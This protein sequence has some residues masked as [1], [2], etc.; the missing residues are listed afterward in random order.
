MKISVA[1][2]V[3]LFALP[4][5]I[6]GLRTPSRSRQFNAK[7]ATRPAAN[8][9]AS[10]KRKLPVPLTREQ[11]LAIGRSSH[12]HS[13]KRFDSFNNTATT[14]VGLVTAPLIPLGGEDDDED[15]AV[16]GDFNGDG[17]KDVAKLISNYI[18]DSWVD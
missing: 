2:V 13:G 3:L 8:P 18:G 10:A 6:F 4:L 14:S 16:I 11:R 7:H 9:A 12:P 17:K 1:V 15:S 5:P